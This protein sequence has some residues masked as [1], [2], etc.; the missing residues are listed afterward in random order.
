[1][2]ITNYLTAACFLLASAPSRAAEPKAPLA[3]D[4]T[5]GAERGEADAQYQ[6]ARAYLRGEGVP[7]DVNKA[8]A[9]MKAAAAQGHANAIGGIGYFHSV[10][11]AV[12]KDEAQ[13]SAW[14]RKGAE[15]GSAKAQLNLGKYL[16]EGKGGSGGE[17]AQLREEGLEWIKKAAD[18]GLPEAA[19][20]YGS[21]F[22]FGDHEVTKDYGKAVPYFKRAAE[23]GSR[24][25]QNFLGVMNQLGLGMAVDKT[26]AQRWLRSAALQNHLKAQANLGNLLNPVAENRATRIE[27]L[28]WLVISSDQ[29]EVT[30]EKSLRDTL[31]GL[32]GGDLEAAKARAEELRKLIKP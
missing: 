10:G 21:I 15:K 19:L 22:Y 26:A 14:F 11:V 5:G 29:H 20:A 24:D 25:A 28:A 7:K 23:Q 1:M 8:F 6:L 18:Q 31:P 27:A 30:A 2:R 9:L 3:P 12:E 17:P 16:L 4:I 32:K 13:A